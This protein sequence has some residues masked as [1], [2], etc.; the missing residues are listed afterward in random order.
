MSENIR[1]TAE[2]KAIEADLAL[3]RS[4][5]A[6]AIYNALARHKAECHGNQFEVHRKNCADC[7][8]PF[9]SPVPEILCHDCWMKAATGK[10]CARCDG[11]QGAPM[12]PS[13]L[14]CW[15]CEG[16]VACETREKTT[17]DSG[18][19]VLRAD[20][21]L[22]KIRA[23]PEGYCLVRREDVE[24]AIEKLREDKRYG[25]AARLEAAAKG[26]Q[27]PTPEK[28]RHDFCGLADIKE[29]KH[30]AAKGDEIARGA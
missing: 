28:H 7:G 22:D 16:W 25:T 24:W 12:K 10:S 29:T 18:Q 4:G 20:I 21:D 30:P 1:D 8:K 2:W 17:T 19:N 6:D 5:I 14:C 3:T 13:H 15:Y 23:I 26:E 11:K 27:P 9:T